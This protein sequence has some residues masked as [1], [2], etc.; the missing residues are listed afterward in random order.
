[1]A[2]SHA[3]RVGSTRPSGRKRARPSH[4]MTRPMPMSRAATSRPSSGPTTQRNGTEV[5]M[6]SSSALVGLEAPAQPATDERPTTATS[7]PSTFQATLRA[8]PGRTGSPRAR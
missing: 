4:L 6:P 7:P 3:T 8:R 2:I 1:M 5:S